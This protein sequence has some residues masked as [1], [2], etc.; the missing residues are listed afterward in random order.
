LRRENEML[1]FKVKRIHFVGIGG[2]GMSGLAEVLHNLGFKVTGSDILKQATTKHLES[3]GIQITYKHLP[4]NVV[5][6][7]VVV[8]SSA[9]PPQNPEVLKAMELK[10]PVI[11]RSEMLAE[12]MRMKY[13]V[14]VS[15]AHGK[16]TTTSM[17]A[18]VLEDGGLDPTVVVGGRIKGLGTGA[19]L[20][21]GAFLVAEADE[22]DR[23]FLI[24]YPTISVITNI[25]EEHLEAY[26]G[27]L[28][29]LKEAFVSFANRVPF[30]G[31]VVVNLDDPGIC[32]ILPRF[33]K[34][35]ITYGFREEADIHVGRG[36]VY[37][38]GAK[39]KVYRGEEELG[40]LILNLPGK[41]NVK[42]ALAA[43]TVALELDIPVDRI[44]NSLKN[45]K[46]VERRFEIKGT[47]NGVTFLDDYAH[48]PTEIEAVL[49]TA[50]KMWKNRIVVLFQPHRYTRTRALYKKFGKSFKNAD[51]V[52][53]TKLYP[54]GE[55]PIEG[56]N[57]S[58]I[59]EEIKKNGHPNVYLIEERDEV[60][61]F[62][63][64]FLKEDDLFITMGA[65]DVW[66]LG[67]TLLN[68]GKET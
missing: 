38:N 45:F 7:D 26:S 14:A 15:G 40:D 4:E 33:N 43:I 66:K 42:N 2:S 58:L 60:L 8:V 49:E 67:D 30:Y 47:K 13:S 54:A 22:S 61:S 36:D 28:D 16:T 12:L 9:I 32:E 27:S 55:S 37:S 51:V 48:H 62:L 5:G 39:F 6:A 19:K 65:G 20:G 35:V 23:S 41:H 31:C 59:Y 50:R 34:R 53:V 57:S 44:L 17:I 11:P 52:V 24:L 46:G 68:T 64:E 29:A 18:K 10:I 3:L 63:S 56:V 21:Q 1:F 25:D